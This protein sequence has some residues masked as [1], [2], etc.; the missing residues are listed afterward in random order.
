MATKLNGGG[1]EGLNGT[2]LKRP[3]L[4]LL[5]LV[6]IGQTVSAQLLSSYG[7]FALVFTAKCFIVD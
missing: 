4:R 6:T 1:G 5:L 3:F 2:L 7:Q